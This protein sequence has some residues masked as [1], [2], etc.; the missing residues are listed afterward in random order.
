MAVALRFRMVLRPTWDNPRLPHFDLSLS[1]SA[2]SA[3]DKN[4]LTWDCPMEDG[5]NS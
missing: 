5:P 3:A 2:D 4:D 1:Q